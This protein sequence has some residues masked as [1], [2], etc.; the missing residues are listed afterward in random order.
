MGSIFYKKI[1]DDSKAT[2]SND[3][4]TNVIE[5]NNDIWMKNVKVFTEL[6][7][8]ADEWIEKGNHVSHPTCLKFISDA[9]LHS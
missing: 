3:F 8:E 6:L 1:A 5:K 4:P 9:R 7:N 2:Q